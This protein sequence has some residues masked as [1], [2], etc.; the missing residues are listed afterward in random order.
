MAHSDEPDERDSFESIA[1]ELGCDLSD[2]ALDKAFDRLDP[3][4]DKKSE[5]DEKE[6]P[7]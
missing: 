1:K 7:D 2:E 3:K 4:V 6:K 5:Q